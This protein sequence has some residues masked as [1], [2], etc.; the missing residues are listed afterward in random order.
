MRK[1]MALPVVLGITACS[2]SLEDFAQKGPAFDLPGYFD[3]H[4]TAY[5]I[6][7]DFKG[8]MTRHF[9][10]DI[11]ASWE[12][13]QGQ[14][15][16]TFYFDDGEQ[17]IRI[18]KLTVDEQGGVTGTAGD[19]VGEASGKAV[20]NAFNWQYELSVPIDG[21]PM[22]FAIDDWLYRLDKNR[23]MNRSYMKK[24]GLTVAEISIFFDKSTNFVGCPAASQQ[25][26]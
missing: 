2:A 1:L 26:S 21:E 4:I 25:D 7:E 22:V 6:I 13:N 10:V 20:G 17:Q 16:E 18:W 19:V 12:N 3:G 9:C 8:Q 24:F 23:L 11:L 15:H 14:L 5:G